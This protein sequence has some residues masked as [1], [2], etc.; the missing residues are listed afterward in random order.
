MLHGGTSLAIFKEWCS[1]PKNTIIIPGYCSP[2]TVGQ[3]LQSG[4]KL[5]EI[6]GKEYTVN[7]AVEHLSFSAHADSKGLMHII[8]YIAPKNIVLIHGEKIGMKQL[9]KK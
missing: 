5:I 3:K 1:N 8:D 2:G 7:C 9:K 6:E 4:Q